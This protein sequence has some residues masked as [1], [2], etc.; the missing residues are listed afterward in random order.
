MRAK[1]AIPRRTSVWIAKCVDQ[2]DVY[3]AAK[4]LRTAA[5]DDGVHAFAVTMAFGSLALQV[6]SIKTGVEIPG[7]IRVTYDVSDG[8]WDQALVQIW[9]PSK[10]ALEWPPSYGLAGEVGLEA[11]TQRLNPAR[12]TS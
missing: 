7:N 10:N 3:S 8:P 12:E 4:D 11:L 6:V 1:N 2:P 9:P 5:G